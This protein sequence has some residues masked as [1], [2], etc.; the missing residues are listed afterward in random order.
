M[1]TCI[2][3]S[4]NFKQSS[5]SASNKGVAVALKWLLPLIKEF[6]GSHP[7]EDRIRREVVHL[8]IGDGKGVT[9][10]FNKRPD[11]TKITRG[12]GGVEVTG[13]KCL[14]IKHSAFG[15]LSWK[16]FSEGIIYSKYIKTLFCFMATPKIQKHSMTDGRKLYPM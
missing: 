9:Q 7:P 4:V 8:G 15:N 14:I 5:S 11:G 10:Y 3:P 16:T 1:L 12:S 13:R 6:G 2:N